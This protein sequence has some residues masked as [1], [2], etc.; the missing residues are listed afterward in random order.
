MTVDQDD[1]GNEDIQNYNYAVE[2]IEM[3]MTMMLLMTMIK[4]EMK[5]MTMRMMMRLI[6][7]TIAMIMVLAGFLSAVHVFT[8][9][10]MERD[11]RRGRTP[12]VRGTLAPQ[13]ATTRVRTPATAGRTRL[14]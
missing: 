3:R 13:P 1:D 4:M 11:R 12:A 7:A 8:L 2:M 6:T 5:M 10:Q 9:A 14:Q